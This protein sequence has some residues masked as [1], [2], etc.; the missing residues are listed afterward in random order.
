MEKEKNKKGKGRTKATLRMEGDNVS[1][2]KN[3]FHS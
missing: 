2:K 3:E 1:H